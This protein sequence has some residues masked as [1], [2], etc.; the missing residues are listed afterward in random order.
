MNRVSA[1]TTLVS[2]DNSA[3]HRVMLSA[4]S[5]TPRLLR[6]DRL[7]GAMPVLDIAQR[8]RVEA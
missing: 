8:M 6:V 1:A 3:K 2:S 7:R 4:R 5:G